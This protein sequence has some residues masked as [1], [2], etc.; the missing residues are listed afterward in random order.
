MG[1]VYRT[2]KNRADVFKSFNYPILISIL[3]C[4]CNVINLECLL[5]C[6]HYLQFGEFCP[7]ISFSHRSIVITLPLTSLVHWQVTAN[8]RIYED[9]SM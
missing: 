2:G 6:E 9:E 8:L 3:S 7:T 1:I 5:S 4:S